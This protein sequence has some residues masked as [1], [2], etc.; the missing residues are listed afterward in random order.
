VVSAMSYY[1]MPAHLLCNLV[2]ALLLLQPTV[3][4]AFAAGLVGSLALTLHNPAPHLFF[5]IPFIVWLSLRRGSPLVLLALFAGYLP[6]LALLGW[7]WQ[8]HLADIVAKPA[9]VAQAQAQANA[10]N[11]LG[12]V[13]GAASAALTPPSARIL[14]ARI[15]GLTKVW[16][17]GSAALMVLAAYGFALARERPEVKVLSAALAITF[18]GYFFVPFDQGH[19]W[20]YRYL[21]SAW[22]VLPVLAALAM[23]RIPDV[24]LRNMAGWALA[25][26]LVAA[27]GLRVSQVDSFIGR[28]LALVPPLARPADPA[29]PEIVFIDARAGSYV[30]DMHQND[31]LLRGPRIVMAYDGAEK[32]AALMARRF[33]EYTKRAE[34]KWGELWTR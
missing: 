14:E 20:G 6:L 13:T 18:F 27:N 9:A 32:S 19:G 16:S 34:G 11:P 10:P 30:R 28:H 3:G 4:R 5:C 7:G 25:L 33:P 12:R 23:S 26:S 2:Y 1:T 24:E 29:R 15:A 17:W 21:H 22:F 31:P 8:Q